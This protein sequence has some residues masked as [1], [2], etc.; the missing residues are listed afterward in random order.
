MAVRPSLLIIARKRRR[1]PIS[2]KLLRWGR[3][4][5]TVS[6]AAIKTGERICVCA[7]P[8]RPEDSRGESSHA[9]YRGCNDLL[10]V[11]AAPFPLSLGLLVGRTS[12]TLAWVSLSVSL[13]K[14]RRD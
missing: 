4:M 6:N 10:R 5:N 1:K 8:R 9:S 3:K 11:P 13:R 12:L 2:A 14:K 7:E